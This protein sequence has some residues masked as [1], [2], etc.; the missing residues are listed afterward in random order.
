MICYTSLDQIADVLVHDRRYDKPARF[1]IRDSSALSDEVCPHRA[2]QGPDTK[3]IAISFGSEKTEEKLRHP[4]R[5][6]ASTEAGRG[7][8]RRGTFTG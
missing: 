6:R 1:W 3:S 8:A 7:V 4:G 2:Q 5:G